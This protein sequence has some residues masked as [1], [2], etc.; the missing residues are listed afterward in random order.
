MMKSIYL[1][2]RLDFQACYTGIL[3][4]TPPVDD[5]RFVRILRLVSGKFHLMIRSQACHRNVGT[6]NGGQIDRYSTES[7]Q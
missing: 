4:L 5:S 7:L 3:G 1:C 2:D 6:C